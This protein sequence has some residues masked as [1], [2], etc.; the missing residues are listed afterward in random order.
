M[1]RSALV[2][3]P[4]WHFY[5]RIL[6][7]AY[8][9]DPDEVRKWLPA[10]FELGPDP[11]L[12]AA[13]FCEWISAPMSDPEFAARNPERSHYHETLL[14][15]GCS[16]NGR[17]GQYCPAIWVDN[18]FTLVRGLMQGYPKK[19]G[20]SIIARPS[21]SSPAQLSACRLAEG[22]LVGATCESAGERVVSGLVKVRAKAS[23]DDLPPLMRRPIYLT[24]HFP[25]LQA[26]EPPLVHDVVTLSSE[27]P[28]FG[29][30]WKGD[31]ELELHEAR[32]E[33][34]TSLKPR[35]IMAGYHIS[36]AYTVKGVKV[37]YRYSAKA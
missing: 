26:G 24:R 10:P 17:A 5:G 23:L 28:D 13:M 19:F 32:F 35:E 4:S 9:T 22:G 16:L 2:S 31:A 20:R 21:E 18:D 25:S 33:E 6:Y 37:L 3:S 27:K 14:M 30:I 36:M 11:E 15:V 1:G 34:H 12:A 29:P 8:K 7:I